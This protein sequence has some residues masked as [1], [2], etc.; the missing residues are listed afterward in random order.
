MKPPKKRAVS[1]VEKRARAVVATGNGSGSLTTTCHK[2][3]CEFPRCLC[4]VSA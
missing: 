3:A 1:L 2:E 4:G